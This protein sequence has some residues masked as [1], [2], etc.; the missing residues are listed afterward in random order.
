MSEL[1]DDISRIV[2]SKIPRRQALRLIVR[3]LT[4]TTLAALNIRRSAGAVHESDAGIEWIGPT[5]YSPFQ[6][7][8]SP[9]AGLGTVRERCTPGK[10]VCEPGSPVEARCCPSGQACCQLGG[11][12]FCCPANSLCVSGRCCPSGNNGEICGASNIACCCPTNT[13]CCND[14]QGLCCQKKEQCCV[15]NGIFGCCGAGFACINN[16][17]CPND[18]TCTDD[19][20]CPPPAN[21]NRTKCC[22]G[23]CCDPSQCCGP[24][25]LKKCCDPIKEKCIQNECEPSP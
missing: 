21:T 7:L 8:C 10:T 13:V 18:G 11:N 16:K 25:G 15:V 24:V 22:G 3:G 6:N 12:K 20:C 17:C 5:S 2:G 4:G 14:N 9:T 19:T 1:F 23:K